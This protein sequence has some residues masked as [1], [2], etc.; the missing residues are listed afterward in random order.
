MKM[1]ISEAIKEGYT[2]YGRADNGFVRIQ[3]LNDDIPTTDF[4][5]KLV[6]AE[7]QSFSPSVADNFLRELIAVQVYD[8]VGDS[9]GDDD[10]SFAY[11]EVYALDWSQMTAKINDILSSHKYYKLTNIQLVPDGQQ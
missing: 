3:E 5:H 9:T 7:K 6:L 4:N 11:D 2:H 8:H 10:P 1:T